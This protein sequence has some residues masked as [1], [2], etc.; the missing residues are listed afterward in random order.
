MILMNKK[1]GL[2]IFIVV[3]ILIVSMSLGI[4][5]FNK[6]DNTNWITDSDYLY[7]IAK[8]YIIAENT[9]LDT[10]D[11]KEK[12]FKVFADY[13][14][15]GIEEKNDKK[16]VY[17]WILEESYYV[18]NDKLRSG[19]GSS[20]PYKFTFEND[21]VVSYQVPM[22]GGY[23]VSSIKKLFPNSIY[24]KAL[25][26][27]MDD[28]K[29]KSQVKEYYSYLDSTEIV[30]VDPDEKIILFSGY[31][32]GY[33]SKAEA[34]TIKGK[35]ID[36]YGNVYE[37]KIPCDKNEEMLIDVN[38]IDRE[39]IEKYKGNLVS[40]L[41]TEDINTI[42]NN[43]NYVSDEYKDIGIT[44]EDSPCSFIYIMMNEN[45]KDLLI[46]NYDSSKENISESA[47]SILDVIVKNNIVYLYD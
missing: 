44:M 14:G 23:Y 2:M 36:K 26:Y 38:N 7:D 21:K 13:K 17:M 8:D 34:N 25:G 43:I 47:K 32:G 4:I 46:Y 33:T 35:C 45:K 41:T 28:S 1:I 15:F 24:N 19:S 11:K 5:I 39:I 9:A 20:M 22:D 42:L 6:Q 40:K 18:R 31:Y 10:G 27:D 37:Y 3:I 29:L 12:D 30:Y 16:Y